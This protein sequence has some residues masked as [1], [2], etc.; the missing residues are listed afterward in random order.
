MENKAYQS[1]KLYYDLKNYS[2]SI[3]SFENMLKD[4]PETDKEEEIRYLIAKSSFSFAEN[5]VFTKKK[6]RYM[7]TVEKCEIFLKKFP[8]GQ[9]L[10]EVN[11]FVAKSKQELKKIDNG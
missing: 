1:S 11:T 7:T 6:E 10:S 5:S 2:S 8:E 3:V 9:K 4:Y